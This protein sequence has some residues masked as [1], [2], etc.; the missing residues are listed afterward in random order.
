MITSLPR[1]IVFA[2]EGGEHLPITLDSMGYNPDQEA[3]TRPDGYYVY[4][5]LQTTSGEGIIHF[6]NKKLTLSEGSGV[7]L[8]PGTPHKYEALS[9]QNWCTYYLTFGGSS[10]RHI[11]ESAGMHSNSF[12]RWE[13]E[14]P[15]TGMLQEMLDRHDAAA[16]MFSLGVSADAYRFMLTLNKYGHLHNNT[17]ISR[18]IDKLQPLLKWM[19]IHY[20]DPSI[21]LYDLAAQL[22]VSGRYLN[23]LFLQ[24]FGLSPYAYFVRLRIRKS[25]ELLVSK[26]A[27]TVKT[28]SGLVGFRDV[29]HFV[30]TFRKQSGTTPD[31]F[32]RLH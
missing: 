11:L 18:N 4:H 32:R 17:S 9:P 29:S 1:R 3:V 28:I 10:A 14:S 13:H 12:Y 19:D 21:G 5:W 20:G 6:E 26:P 24:T 8:L 27:M 16:D 2:R 25:K 7:L 31:Q 22:D 23:S 15:L 30:A